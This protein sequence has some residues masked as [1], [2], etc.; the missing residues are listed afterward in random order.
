MITSKDVNFSLELKSLIQAKDDKKN[1]RN[2]EAN[3]SPMT[4]YLDRHDPRLQK[5]LELVYAN[6]SK[7]F[8]IFSNGYCFMDFKSREGVSLQDWNRGL[9]GFAIKMMPED[10]KKVF[11]YLTDSTENDINKALMTHSQ[12]MKLSEERKQ[13]NIDPFELIVFR[14]EES[15]RLHEIESE[16]KR[17]QH[18][19]ELETL[20]MAPSNIYQGLGKQKKKK[21]KQNKQGSLPQHI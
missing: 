16:N 14:E 15:A 9:D 7:R 2:G 8:Q 19:V 6:I 11:Q 10:S 17:R 12:F 5:L 1:P 13:R 20:S 18:Q 4:T 3:K 21:K